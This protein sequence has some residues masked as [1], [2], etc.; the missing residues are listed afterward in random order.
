MSSET[1]TNRKGW[2]ICGT[3]IKEFGEFRAY[4]DLNGDPTYW[5][6]MP[7]TSG[8]L[9]REGHASSVR[10]GH[11]SS[12]CEGMLAAEWAAHELR[13]ATSAEKVAS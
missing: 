2:T 6:I 11:A 9:V 4:V 1:K 10:E 3:L 8:Q 5:W 7:R 13:S 12:V